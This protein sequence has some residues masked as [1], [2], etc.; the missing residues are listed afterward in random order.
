MLQT[1][2]QARFPL[3]LSHTAIPFATG[4]GHAL[5]EVPQELRLVLDTHVPVPAGQRWNP[6]A[7]A[8]LHWL[9]VHTAEALGSDGVAQVAHA[10]AVP[11]CKVLSSG[12]QPLVPGQVCVP[13]PQTTPQAPA[14]HAVPS[15]HGVQSTPGRDPQVADA[16]LLTQTPWQ[17]CQP[18][19]HAGTH[20]PAALQV[21]LPLS[22]GG[23]QTVQLLPH[24]LMLVLP[25]AT[26]VVDAPLPHG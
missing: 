6:G 9:A 17:R 4:A 16:L 1:T 8:V 15:G 14:T 20:I 5:H 2:R 23:V 7:H 12:K 22:A 26:Q 24:E 21:T 10:A 13:G 25:L 19:L 3:G 11:H 18:A